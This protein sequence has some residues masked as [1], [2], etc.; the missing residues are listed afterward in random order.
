MT[1]ASSPPISPNGCKTGMRERRSG[2]NETYASKPGVIAPYPI[3]LIC[4]LTGGP[5]SLAAAG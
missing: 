3:C 1:N 5:L 2:K 4:R